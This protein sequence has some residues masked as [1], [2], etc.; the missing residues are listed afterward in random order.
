[1]LVFC[2]SYYL[3]LFRL[4]GDSCVL[5]SALVFIVGAKARLFSAAGIRVRFKGQPIELII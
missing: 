1:M 2:R 5:S 3:L 4:F